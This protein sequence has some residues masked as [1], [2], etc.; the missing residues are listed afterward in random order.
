M[1][2]LWTLFLVALTMTFLKRHFLMD[3]EKFFEG[4]FA[5][6]PMLI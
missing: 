3:K 5:S 4:L 1:E 6:V 2:R